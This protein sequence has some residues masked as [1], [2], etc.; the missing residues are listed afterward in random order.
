MKGSDYLLSDIKKSY[1]EIADTRVPNWRNLS[2]NELANLYLDNEENLYLAEGYFSALVLD[3]WWSIDKNYRLSKNSVDIDTCYNWLIDSLVLA[4]KERKWRE[5]G[6]KI[7]GD[8]NGPH[9]VITRCLYSARMGFYYLANMDKRKLNYSAYSLDLMENQQQENGYSGYLESLM[10]DSNEVEEM[11]KNKDIEYYIQN[12]LS[13][14]D[15]ITA[16]VV[17]NLCFND[18]IFRNS[19]TPNMRFSL[20][21]LNKA[22]NSLDKETLSQFTNKYLIKEEQFKDMLNFFTNSSQYIINKRTKETLNKLKT[23]K[24]LE[25]LIC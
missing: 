5:E 18:D 2:G 22:M 4:L 12:K 17:D 8:P 14:G 20:S 21:R 23:D 25:A 24:Q 6:N 19:S 13:E 7:Y 10:D 1:I 11:L 16:L 3:Y 15:Y 9:M